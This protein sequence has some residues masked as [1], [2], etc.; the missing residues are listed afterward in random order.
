MS[1]D[2][3]TSSSTTNYLQVAQPSY[4]QTFT[5]SSPATFGSS[6]WQIADSWASTF[7]EFAWQGNWQTP[8]F[9]SI[10]PQQTHEWD[11][12]CGIDSP[13]PFE[14]FEYSHQPH[15]DYAVA[16]TQ[17]YN[18]NVEDN[19]NW[20]N[21]WSNEYTAFHP[22]SFPIHVNSSELGRK[23]LFRLLSA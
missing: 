20:S 21:N 19:W 1:D 15:I 8:S 12:M 4:N 6:S 18:T 23:I 7:E 3:T 22:C 13:T 5:D 9:N 10:P 17:T 16:E 11:I 14:S 2:N